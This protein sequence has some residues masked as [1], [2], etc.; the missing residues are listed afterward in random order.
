VT[1][2]RSESPRRCEKAVGG[3]GEQVAVPASRA[4][5]DTPP[6]PKRWWEGRT[7]M[8]YA[9]HAATLVGLITGVAGLIFLVRPE[10]Q[11]KPSTPKPPP[12]KEAARL[13]Q[14][15]VRPGVSR[16]QYFALTDQQS[17]GFTRPQLE[18]DGVFLRFRVT[19][20]GFEGLPLTLRRELF[21]ANTGEE[22]TEE[23][24]TTITP[25]KSTIERDWHDWAPLPERP[26]RFF[27]VIKL[28]AKDESAP[29]ATLETREFSG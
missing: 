19:I 2:D 6:P 26:G 10:L 29:L 9:T 17:T 21:D 8:G 7:P 24:S 23:T 11:P 25:P 5:R 13:K 20:R 14:L 1:D 18:K 28:L 4:P 27:V 15:V 16:A 22:V 3:R 12:A